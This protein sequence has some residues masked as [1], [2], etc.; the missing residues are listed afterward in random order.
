MNT[1]KRKLKKAP[2]PFVFRGSSQL[3]EKLVAAMRASFERMFGERYDL[4]ARDR[5]VWGA[6]LAERGIYWE[7]VLGDIPKSPHAWEGWEFRR[8]LR[9][10]VMA[11]PADLQGYT[12]ARC[13]FIPDELA[14]RM[15][16]LG[17]LM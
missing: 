14:S 11:R 9:G 16:V 5:K 3:E 1:S 7:M 6:F 8:G 15:I 17:D 2:I 12:S 4:N 13:Y 10:Q